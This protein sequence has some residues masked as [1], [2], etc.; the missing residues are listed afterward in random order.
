MKNLKITGAFVF[1]TFLSVAQTKL[2]VVPES[3]MTLTGALV[4]SPLKVKE[5]PGDFVV[6][7]KKGYI[8]YGEK[9]EDIV[10]KGAAV[11]VTLQKVN[12]L[13]AETKTKKIEF[14]KIVDASGKLGTGYS[15]YN[16]FGGS[17]YVPPKNFDDP[18]WTKPMS[19]TMS[20]W[21]YR[22]VGTNAIFEEKGDAPDLVVAGEIAAFGKDTRGSGFQVSVLM[23][24]SVYNVNQKK[25]VSTIPAGGYSDSKM[26]LSFDDELI[27]AMQDALVGLMSNSEFQEMVKSGSSGSSA[28][29]EVTT[30]PKITA[31]KYGSYGEM[32]KEV[33]GSVVTVKTS[34]I[35]HGSGFVIGKDGYILTNDHVVAGAEEIEIIF[36][37]G[38]SMEGKVVK[39]DQERDV[40][41][42]K[43]S[44]SGFK[45]LAINSSVELTTVGSEVI[46]IGTPAD[47]KLG[48]TVTK[49]I[50]SG[51]REL[52]DDHDV[53]NNYIQTD[54]TINPGN[55]GGPLLTNNGEVVGVVVSKIKGDGIEGL[56]FAIP[57]GEALEKL[58]IKF[59]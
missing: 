39:T 37:N 31:T 26:D 47:I 40:A 13:P 30:L 14:A 19:K 12:K 59:E 2:T 54:V 53:K 34:S 45:P 28:A 36:D 23:N 33:I 32:I 9:V 52:E 44:G 35:A 21:G 22:I 27:L 3:E 8:T 58:S 18:K 1:L 56:A 11:T 49:G 57:I 6:A 48:Q 43:I 20:D 24:W 51:K 17:S 46:A 42:V 4:S 29:K 25:V 50:I 38:F 5:K 7:A 15:T 41:L 10:K 16:P 55:S